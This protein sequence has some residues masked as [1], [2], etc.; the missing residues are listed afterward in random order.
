MRSHS[1]ISETYKNA[2]IIFHVHIGYSHTYT[3]MEKFIASIVF[4][5][6]LQNSITASYLEYN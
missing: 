1:L 4:I 2:S 5:F 3:T 6:K